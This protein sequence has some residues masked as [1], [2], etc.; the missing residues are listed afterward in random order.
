MSGKNRLNRF[1]VNGPV[2]IGSGLSAR[3]QTI[4]PDM[5]LEWLT[6]N[7]MN[8]KVSESHVRNIAAAMKRGEWK[9]NGESLII[10]SSGQ[11]LNAQHRLLACIESEMPFETVVIYGVNPD[12]AI[13]ETIDIGKKR[14]IADILGLLNVKNASDIA[15]AAKL[16]MAWEALGKPSR[17]FSVTPTQIYDWITAHP[18]IQDSVTWVK[19]GR[20]LPGGSTWIALHFRLSNI[21]RDAAFVFFSKVFGGENLSKGDPAYT[22]RDKM[23]KV[24]RATKQTGRGGFDPTFIAAL[25]VKAWN[26]YRKKKEIYELG[27]NVMEDSFPI[28][29]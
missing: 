18:N 23:I 15:A 3:V 17:H 7:D 5:A 28:A 9:L 13:M 19:I 27:F 21:D 22:L 8:R 20:V 10:A 25:I 16:N 14:S 12:A 29:I 2:P 11:I 24:A 4:T 26:A 6:K 1:T